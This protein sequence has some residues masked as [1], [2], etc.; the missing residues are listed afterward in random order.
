LIANTPTA[1]ERRNRHPYRSLQRTRKP[2]TAESTPVPLHRRGPA[3]ENAAL[4][5]PRSR[6][7][8]PLG[9][10][11]RHLSSRF[12]TVDEVEGPILGFVE[13]ATDVFAED[14]DGSELHPT[15]EQNGRQQGGITGDRITVEQRSDHNEGAVCK[16]ARRRDQS[17][18]RGDAQW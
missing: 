17:E 3:C 16:G 1:S 12:V 11:P 15:Q 13:D 14:P 18:V 7:L 10:G 8:A 2:G 6:P 9:V 4:R 5:L